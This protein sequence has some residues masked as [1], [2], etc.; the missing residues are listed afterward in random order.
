MSQREFTRRVVLRGALRAAL[1]AGALTLDRALPLAA[2]APRQLGVQVS[3]DFTPIRQGRVGL[4]RVQAGDDVTAV[5]AMFQ[6]RMIQF[7]P[8]AGGFIGLLAVNFEDDIGTY[9]MQVWAEHADGT[10]EVLDFPV[11]VTYGEFGSTPVNLPASLQPLLA[12][13]IEEAEMEQL[14]NIMNRFTPERY[15]EP[16]GFIIPN[17]GPQIGY[18]GTWRLYNDTY[19]RR[20]TGLDI[21][22]PV[23]TAV[24][25]I[26]NGRVMMAEDLLIRGGYVL[27]DH[28]W[29]VY[30]GYAH[31][32]QKMVVPGQ[33]V[34]QSDVIALS[35]MNGRSAGA[36]LHWEMVVSGAWTQPEDFM[37]LSI[38]EREDRD[39]G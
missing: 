15:W 28:G 35:G 7:Y 9:T 2:A 20:H 18:F 3:L 22:M 4:A 39:A 24:N 8:D 30:S 29:G 21:S 31:L 33:W 13:E 34:R 25:V 12:P 27:I 6:N 1:A 32:S 36:H 14:F 37:R 10:L 23:G 16:N 11:E 19:W 38:F 17:P 26:A 5:R